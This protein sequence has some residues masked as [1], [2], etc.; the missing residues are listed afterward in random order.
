MTNSQAALGWQYQN[1]FIVHDGRRW[2]SLAK[3]WRKEYQDRITSGI[4]DPNINPQTG[5]RY[6][7]RVQKTR[8]ACVVKSFIT[9]SQYA[10]NPTWQIRYRNDV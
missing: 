10:A 5:A 7:E 6:S 1:L 8:N 3:N 4:T 9:E 2:F